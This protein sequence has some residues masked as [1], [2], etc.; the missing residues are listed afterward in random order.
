[1]TDK[2]SDSTS[3]LGVFD[4]GIGGLTV[5]REL[6]RI[7]PEERLRYFGDTAR[8][9][10]GTKSGETVIR[11]TLEAAHFLRD[12]GVKGLVVACNT[13]SA[14]ALTAVE[15]DLGIPVVGVIESG[16]RAALAQTR[17]R[18]IGVI[19]TTAT[20][21]SG[22]YERALKTLAPDLSLVA[23]ACPL[24]VPLV[25]EGWTDHP[26]TRQVAE[27]YLTPL[28]AVG[29]DTL[30]LGCT[31]YP[32]LKYLL[33]QVMGPDVALIDAGEQT[34]REVGLRLDAAGL[35]A[36]GRGA[37]AGHGAAADPRD[38]VALE[39]R[40]DRIFLTDLQ[41]AFRATGERFLGR[42]LPPV[43]VLRWH[44]ERWIRA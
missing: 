39:S 6:V 37:G 23:K 14:Y 26:V 3:P 27:E 36:R 9:P 44:E 18:K 8:V 4:S 2:L 28:R 25:E 11:F 12:Q 33:A 34:A 5:F 19:A 16:A 30:I 21:T 24:F 7:L 15:D 31:H 22:A 29:V 32:L 42:K 38:L 43:E 10:Y 20:I 1:M 40:D 17:N 13:A 35:R 41:P